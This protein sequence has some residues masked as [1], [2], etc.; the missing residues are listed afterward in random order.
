M[1]EKCGTSNAKA[2]REDRKP[3]A[4]W[5]R[6]RLRRWYQSHRRMF[7]WRTE[8]RDP[9][10][11]LVA[12][13]MLQQTQVWRVEPALERFLERFPTLEHLARAARR[14]VLVAWQGLGYNRRAVHLHESA[15]AIVARF[16]GVI[17]ADL[18]QLRTLPGIGDYTARAIAAFAYGKD[19]AVVDV[20][21]QRVLSRVFFPLQSQAEQMPIETVR[22][23][24]EQL[25]PRGGGRW[26]NEALMDLGSLVCTKR[27]PRCTECPL[28]RRCQSAGMLQPAEQQA[29]EEPCYRNVPRR[30][31]R[32]RLV[33]LL[34]QR[35]SCTLAEI[36]ELLFGSAAADD[37]AWLR[38]LADQM[39][40][41][42]VVCRDGERL[43]LPP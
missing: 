42:G 2:L 28:R 9:Y 12:E 22:R 33:E 19:V 26:W 43:E 41:D 34:R 3:S 14:D 40:S 29:K 27:S 6:Q 36:A 4:V 23:I 21:I 13:V 17:P 35:S 10:V 30:L 25:L 1:E 8:P 24:A 31:W 18:V 39:A 32:G 7:R 11:V 38:N 37:V 15:R 16:G 5:L 20:N